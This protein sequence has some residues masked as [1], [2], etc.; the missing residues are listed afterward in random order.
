MLLLLHRRLGWIGRALNRQSSTAHF[1][2]KGNAWIE[3]HEV[4]ALQR[5]RPSMSAMP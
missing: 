2:E 5:Q 3:E 1:I 4:A